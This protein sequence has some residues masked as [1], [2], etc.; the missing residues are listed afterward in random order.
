MNGEPVTD[1]DVMAALAA[2]VDGAT[3]EV[4]VGQDVIHVEGDRLADAARAARDLGFELFSDLCAVD[5][6]SRRPNRFDVVVN[7]VS[8]G[9]AK[10]VRI[11]AGVSGTDPAVPSITDVFA[12]ANFYEREAYDLFGIGFEG[13]PDLSRILLP[14]DWTGH[15]LRKDTPVG[16]VPV[17]FKE[18]NRVT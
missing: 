11:V 14:D 17:Q 1:D 12:G 10:R 3:H 6:L 8:I 9:R 2:A 16:S 18:A 7:L 5:H 13:H 15:P 4:T